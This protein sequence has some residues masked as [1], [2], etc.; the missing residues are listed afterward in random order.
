MCFLGRRLSPIIVNQH[1]KQSSKASGQIFMHLF[2]INVRTLLLNRKDSNLGA[3]FLRLQLFT[4][5][6]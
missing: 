2:R 1:L 5:F 3:L 4:F 6:A